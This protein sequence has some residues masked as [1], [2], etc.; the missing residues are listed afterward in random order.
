MPGRVWLRIAAGIAIAALLPTSP[1]LGQHNPGGSTPPPSTGTPGN[2]NNTPAINSNTNLN[3]TQPGDLG[4]RTVFLTGAVKIEDGTPLPGQVLLER[5]CGGY[6]KAEA[7]TDLKGQFSIQ[8]GQEQAITSDASFE[9]MTGT[10]GNSQIYP[11]VSQTKTTG[12]PTAQ[13]QTATS[14]DRTGSNRSLIGCELTA[15]LPGFRSDAINLSGRR[16]LDNPDV[17]TLF[18]H[19]LANVE[20]T[21]VS[22]TMLAAPKDARK[23]YDKAL[24]ALRK[25]KPADAWKELEKAVELYPHFAA[26]WYQLGILREK[27]QELAV[28]RK[29]Y[30]QA[31]AADPQFVSPYLPLTLLEARDK[32][33]QAMV[34]TTGR[35][36]KL[37]SVD[38]PDVYY[39]SAAA[40]YNLKQLDAA[41]P[42]AREAVK[43]DTAHRNPEANHLLGLI[44]FHKKDYA[45]AAEQMRSYLELAP[46]AA[47]AGEVR[48]QLADLERRAAAAAG[49]SSER[50]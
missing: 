48:V 38:F 37:D 20:G 19:R 8:L 28:A 35:L 14:S 27:N 24:E 30:E 21:T 45:G 15:V 4:Q 41:E 49:A 39:Y 16:P 43:L 7:Y 46:N 32:D 17:G 26:A 1:A 6:R 25:G 29:S 9:G 44:L 36:L 50:Q 3:N 18:L 42:N 47:E 31:I 34:N 13:T 40:N 22:A 12:N 10:P 23:A 2:P 5:V 33:W 11:G